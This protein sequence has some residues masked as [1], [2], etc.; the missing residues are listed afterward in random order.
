MHRRARIHGLLSS[1]LSAFST[2]FL[3]FR[4]QLLPAAPEPR[5]KKY[6]ETVQVLLFRIDKRLWD[7]YL[8]TRCILVKLKELVHRFYCQFPPALRPSL[9]SVNF[10]SSAN[11]TK[12]A[13]T[14][15]ALSFFF[16]CGQNVTI[17]PRDET[18]VLG[19]GLLEPIAY[20]VLVW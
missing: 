16:C 19:C 13:F 11:P 2:L 10:S 12:V 1:F 4:W 7:G 17:R 5:A 6:E 3:M 9:A 18:S 8:L 14:A 15:K 20:V